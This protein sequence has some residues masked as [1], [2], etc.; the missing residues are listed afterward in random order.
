MRTLKATDASTDEKLRV[1]LEGLIKE[2]D[3]EKN[4]FRGIKWTIAAS[5]GVASA[6]AG[7]TTFLVSHFVK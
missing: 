4:F 6:V 7:V 5:V 3:A 1:A 2:R